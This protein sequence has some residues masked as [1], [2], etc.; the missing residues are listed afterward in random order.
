M[1]EGQRVKREVRRRG[2]GRDIGEK[3]C[4]IEGGK[5]KEKRDRREHHRD[6]QKEGEGE[7]SRHYGKNLSKIKRLI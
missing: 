5:Y 1:R 4:K 7:N 2:R 6:R 3:V